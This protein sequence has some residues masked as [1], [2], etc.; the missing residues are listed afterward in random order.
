MRGV[1]R[2]D[3]S[4]SPILRRV[5]VP[6]LRAL[7][8][9]QWVKNVFVL[10]PVVFAQRLTEGD[11]LARA[12]LVFVVF[13]AAASA[14]YLWNDLRDRDEDRKHPL[15]RHRPIAS[16]AVSLTVATVGALLLAIT[17]LGLAAYLGLS[18]AI[19]VAVYLMVNLLYAGGLK[20]V[21][22]LDVMAV[23]SG[24]VIR[25]EAGA[26]AIPVDVSRWLVLCTIFLALFLVLSKR[27]HELLLLQGDAGAHRA[28]LSHYSP[29]FLDQMMNVVTPSTVVAYALY[30]VDDDTVARFGSD[31]LV[32]TVPLVLFGIFRYLYLVYQVRAAKNPTETVVTDV[33]SVINIALW[34]AVVLYL[35]WLR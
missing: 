16:G 24:Y 3:V 32:W 23:A 30:A 19:L 2:A 4:S 14:V 12:G 15:K 33:P 28:V 7:R 8:P 11:A 21:V 22:V 1:G 6:F 5:I 10:A 18:V 13:C 31:L 17:A 9:I 25:V 20:H 35:T 34:G 29:E 26:Q 27:R